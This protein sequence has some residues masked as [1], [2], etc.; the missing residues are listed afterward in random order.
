MARNDTFNIDDLLKIPDAI[1]EFDHTVSFINNE[2]SEIIA[3][4]AL[5]I[6]S[7]LNEE[8][9]EA[10]A[11]V[12][13]KIDEAVNL[14]PVAPKLSTPPP[15]PPI[16]AKPAP[17]VIEEQDLVLE[18]EITLTPIDEITD[19]VLN[20]EGF[21]EINLQ[22][23]LSEDEI[24]NNFE[25]MLALQEENQYYV[26]IEEE[27]DI[28][29]D[30]QFTRIYFDDEKI[31][32]ELAF[33]DPSY[34]PE[35]KEKTIIN[36]IEEPVNE[37]EESTKSRK[38]TKK[39]ARLLHKENL[40]QVAQ[41]YRFEYR[42][43]KICWFLGI[44]LV[45][46]TIVCFSLTSWAIFGLGYST[47]LYLPNTLFGIGAITYFIYAS[48][49][50]RGMYKELKTYGYKIDKETNLASINR[51]YKQLITSNYY[52]NWGAAA[53]YMV[54]GMLILL[55]FIVTYFINVFDHGGRASTFGDLIIH[56]LQYN[57]T[58]FNTLST[59]ND[60]YIVVWTFAA[61][62]FLV[63]FLQMLYNPLNI[64]RRNQIETFYGR[65]LISEETINQLKKNAN[66]KGI[67]IFATSTFA[68]SFIVLV[69]Y[70][71]LRR[72]SKK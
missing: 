15:P 53:L 31:E 33:I 51:V 14:E 38:A 30:Q 63:L 47:W 23:P 5:S 45:L 4:K 64:Y 9:K 41:F 46:A 27:Q 21:D 7:L 16:P 35:V 22:N 56:Y 13:Q 25:E 59:N 29:N 32:E 2:D 10:T 8:K 1:T 17:V 44:F 70:L 67:A 37:V 71:V 26:N 61:I 49:K 72:K 43:A 62:C 65:T 20:V 34:Q 18:D 50:V 69:T 66:R 28:K 68:V 54:S 6:D 48:I 52:L 40:S 24:Q 3:T 39:A 57:G 58:S 12:H 19:S 55:T 36:S 60:A 42:H 11:F